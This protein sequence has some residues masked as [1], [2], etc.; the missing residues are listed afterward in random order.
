MVIV[1][2]EVIREKQKAPFN[3]GVGESE[4][5]RTDREVTKPCCPSKGR[6]K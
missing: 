1:H 2:M 4:K 3:P 5:I 6:L